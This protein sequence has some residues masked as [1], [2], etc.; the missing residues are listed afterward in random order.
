MARVQQRARAAVEG[1]APLRQLHPIVGVVVVDQIKVGFVCVYLLFIVAF[2]N[3]SS[4]SKDEQ[5][6]SSIQSTCTHGLHQDEVLS[7]RPPKTPR[8]PIV[9]VGEL[10]KQR[11]RFFGVRRKRLLK[12]SATAVYGPPVHVKSGLRRTPASAVIERHKLL[13]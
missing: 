8:K 3:Q 10:V 1:G 12:G 9:I 13:S 2:Q 5:T 11:K 7:E 4:S 6:S